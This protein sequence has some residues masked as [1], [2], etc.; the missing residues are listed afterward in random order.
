MDK[1]A[2]MN[3]FVEIVDR[4][5]LT[6]AGE[7]LERSLPAVVRTLAALEADLGVRLLRR[8]TRRMS[9]T[10]EGRAY[11]ERCRRILADIAEAEAALV[12]EQAE[13]R[14]RIRATAPLLFGQ[15]HVAPA[16]T[17][18]VQRY[19][20]TE[21]DLLLLDRVV[22]LVEEG[23]DVAVRIGPLGD[24]T[25]IAT[26]VG[27]VRRVVCASPELLEQVG[28]PDRPQDLAAH[29]CVRFRALVSGSTW[30]FREGRRDLSVEVH[31]PF[32]CNQASATVEAC[33]AGLGFGL[34]L[35][36]QVE[37]LVRDGRLQVVLADFE[38]PPLPVSVVYP[39]ARLM[40]TRLRAFVDWLK[41]R[42]ASREDLARAS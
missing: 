12:S 8:T 7:A 29:P 17:A 5:S 6:A 14:G 36:Y 37:S 16:V 18:F 1:L 11:L 20:E 42:L 40:S 4:G 28:A 10:E 24:S 19:P 38:P 30:H 25:M 41:Q 21:V 34:F 27:R 35:S 9:L 2:A 39:D 22:H 33:A 13:P 15:L 3:A 31:G 26:G 23:I 32:A